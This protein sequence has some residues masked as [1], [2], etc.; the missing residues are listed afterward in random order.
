MIEDAKL[1]AML[2]DILLFKATSRE[3][4]QKYGV[5][6]ATVSRF[7]RVYSFV[8]NDE[9]GKLKE[10]MKT[11][12]GVRGFSE[13]SAER[14]GKV[15]PMDVYPVKE[16][17][18]VKVEEPPAEEQKT[19]APR[20]ADA[21]E[22]NTALVITSLLGMIEKQNILLSQMAKESREQTELL[23]QVIDTVLPHWVTDLKECVNTNTDLVCTQ[24]DESKKL[25]DAVKCNTRRRG[26]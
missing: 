9:W 24:L 17:K 21:D 11:E 19:E 23:T 5:S 7:R 8:E 3:V 16:S 10:L 13:W 6:T 20:Q 2:C 25:L 14:L 22:Q 26:A 4:A 1:N 15:I 12:N 18:P